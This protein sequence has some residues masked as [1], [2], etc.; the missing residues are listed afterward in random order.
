MNVDE[1][2]LMVRELLDNMTVH[3]PNLP[4]CVRIEVS[5]DADTLYV[6]FSNNGP[7]ISA[8]DVDHLFRPFFRGDR[9]RRADA[10]RVGLGLSLAARAAELHYGHLY[11][12]ET[13]PQG[14]TFAVAFPLTCPAR[15]EAELQIG[16]Q[17]RKR[18]GAWGNNGAVTR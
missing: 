1:M 5:A 18:L 6:R 10:T 8:E 15:P 16:T 11:L 7:Q 3:N 9:A 12:E 13:T 4:K 2:G 14:S 17:P